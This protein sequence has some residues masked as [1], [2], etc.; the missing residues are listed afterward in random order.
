MKNIISWSLFSGLR[1][2][3]AMGLCWLLFAAGA[4]VAGPLPPAHDWDRHLDRDHAPQPALVA[5]LEGVQS[6]ADCALA[7]WA[8]LPVDE[9]ISTVRA[10]SSACLNSLFSASGDVAVALFNEN[11]ML[12]VAQAFTQDANQYDGSAAAGAKALVLFLRAG[13]YV[14]FYGDELPDYSPQLSQKIST[15]MTVLLR[16]S[17]FFVLTERNAEYVSEVV[18]LVDSAGINLQHLPQLTAL[19]ASLNV[20]NADGYWAPLAVNNVLTVFFRAHYADAADAWFAD[21]L[22]VIEDLAAMASREDLTSTGSEYVV[23]N[24]AAETAR[25]Y[26]YGDAFKA[27]IDAPL[28]G[29]LQRYDFQGVGASIWLAAADMIDYYLPGQ[30]QEFGLCGF[31]D[32][33][34][35]AI[36]SIRHQCPST[37]S[38][39]AQSLTPQQR[40]SVCDDLLALQQRFHRLFGQADSPV[41]DDYNDQLEVVIF[42]SSDQYQLYGGVLFDIST[43]NGGIYL[44]GD[45]SDRNNQARFIAYVAEWQSEFEV[46]NLMHEAVHYLDGRFN[47][48]GDFQDTLSADTVWWTEGIAEYVSK[49]DDNA[50]AIDTGDSNAWPLSTLFANS[51]NDTSARI[52]DGGYLAARYM[53]TQQSEQLDYLLMHSRSGDYSGYQASLQQLGD[54]LDVDYSSWLQCLVAGGDCDPDGPDGGNGDV[55]LQ[56][57]AISADQ[58]VWRFVWVPAGYERIQVTTSGGTGDVDVFVKYDGWPSQQDY[59][60]ASMSAGNE[61]RLILAAQG[62]E[63]LHLLLSPKAAASNVRLTVSASPAAIQ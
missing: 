51:Y 55:L 41:A 27:A 9:L 21:H 32:D 7:D 29:L 36:L 47:M 11:T 46:W 48:Q 62:G 2:R 17:G 24:A 6:H 56:E 5:R 61:E 1:S 37:F 60:A 14:Q 31:V 35:A 18:T 52:Y 39:R 16:H 43:N 59:D 20:S 10:A 23:A 19:F 57:S 42:A 49:L 33:I 30:C 44:E 53:F 28:K 40:D 3:Y 4:A 12:A 22:M 54:S 38:V 34:D 26:Q 15:G 8:A 63:Y 45:P 13:F 58:A 25:F 50:D